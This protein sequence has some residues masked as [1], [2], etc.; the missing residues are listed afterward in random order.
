MAK[1]NTGKIFEEAIKKSIEKVDNTYY[2]RLRDPASS[3]NQTDNL[4]FSIQNDYDCL[5][6][7]FP[8]FYPLELKSTKGTSFSIQFEKPQK[9]K[10]I[11][12]N[13]IKG[14]TK[15]SDVNGVYAGF[16]FNFSEKAR[17]YWLDIKHFN[18]FV[19]ST[20]KK[21]INEKDIVDLGGIL[22][23]QKLKKVNYSY[24]IE[25]MISDINKTEENI[26]QKQIV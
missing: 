12:L 18:E 25:H 14:L 8:H 4:R 13:Q 9:G 10:M 20:E 16:M 3:F 15:A 23:N 1:K 21:S 24:D 5:M 6:Y 26:C 19:D 22:I 7:Q 2:Y 17:T 11:K